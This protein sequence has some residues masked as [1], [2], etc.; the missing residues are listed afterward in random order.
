[1]VMRIPRARTLRE[2]EPVVSRKIVVSLVNEWDVYFSLWF[3]RN[4]LMVSLYLLEVNFV[5]VDNGAA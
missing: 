4:K 1:M 3:L 5:T 2:T